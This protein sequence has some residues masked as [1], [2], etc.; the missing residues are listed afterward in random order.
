MPAVSE[1][2]RRMMAIAKH[3]PGK[4]YKRNRPALSMTEEQLNEFASTK[5]KGLPKKKKKKTAGS[6]ARQMLK[7]QEGYTMPKQRNYGPK[8][9]K[10]LDA[11]YSRYQRDRLADKTNPSLAPKDRFSQIWGWIKT[12]GKQARQML[13]K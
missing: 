1:A 10:N 13:G 5:E 2:Q 6:R 11:A 12:P 9:F 3:S 8:Q 7:Q 4:L